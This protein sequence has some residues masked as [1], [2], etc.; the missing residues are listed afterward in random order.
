MTR[1]GISIEFADYRDYTEGDDLRHL[2]WNVLA[3]LQSPVIKTYRDEEDLAVYLLL[4]RSPSM[5]FGES[6]KIDF[7]SKLALALGFVALMSGDAA[8]PCALPMR[9]APRVLR[10]RSSYPQLESW[11]K[12]ANKDTK[13]GKSLATSLRDFASSDHRPGLVILISDTLDEGLE[14]QLRVLTGRGHQVDV[15]QVLSPEEV[16]PDI[17]GDLRLLDAEDGLPRE[18][19]ANRQAVQTYQQNLANHTEVIRESVRRSGGRFLRV[20]TTEKLAEIINGPMRKEGW[21]AR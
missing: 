5:E 17:E 19:T 12:N 2:D 14:I 1:K 11:A 16:E 3:R 10:G 8:Y 6:L 7:A 13:T 18:I 9:T 15:L 4:D 20:L 21:F